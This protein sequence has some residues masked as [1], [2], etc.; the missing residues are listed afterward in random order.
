MSRF[1]ITVLIATRDR[2]ALLERQFREF[3][4]LDSTGL[5][6]EIIVAD[7]GSRDGTFE[8]LS[9]SEWRMPVRVIR[10]PLPGKN[11]AL[12]RALPAAEG[13]LVL[14]TDDDTL[15][16]PNWLS[17]YHRASRLWPDQAIFCGPVEPLFPPG[18]PESLRG[19]NFKYA[20]SAFVAF[21]PEKEEGPIDRLPFGPNFAVRAEILNR[22][23]FCEDIGPSESLKYTMGSETELLQRLTSDGESVIF[24]PQAKVLHIIRE[25]QI[26]LRW[27]KGRGFRFGRYQVRLGD[28]DTQA[29]R[30]LGAP[31]Y[32]WRIY[33]A[34]RV[35][36]AVHQAL[37]SSQRWEYVYESK[38]IQGQIYE[39]RQCESS[40]GQTADQR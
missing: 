31:R 36:S 23:R 39:Y 19:S 22:Y 18:T 13:N 21:L 8:W 38:M 17:E 12:N 34:S 1:D 5:T 7:N 33:I 35:R 9:E 37:W 2:R 14:F 11:R 15:V 16:P 26:T 32:L 3:E 4:K 20:D 10:E 25:E 30:L 24:I 29:V 6:F 27:L 28:R 40:N